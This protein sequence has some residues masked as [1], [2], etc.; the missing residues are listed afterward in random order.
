MLLRVGD[1]RVGHAERGGDGPLGRRGQGERA[2]APP[3]GPLAP[4]A[5]A[6]NPPPLSCSSGGWSSCRCQKRLLRSRWSPTCPTAAATTRSVSSLSFPPRPA[7]ASSRDCLSCQMNSSE[8]SESHNGGGGD[9]DSSESDADEPSL[10]QEPK[11]PRNPSTGGGSQPGSAVHRPRGRQLSVPLTHTSGW[12]RALTCA[13]SP[14]GPSARAGASWSMDSGSDDS[15]R[16]SD[17]LSIDE[18]DGFVFVNYSEGQSKPAHPSQGSVPQPLPPPAT[19]PRTYNQLRAGGWPRFRR[20][21]GFLRRR[22]VSVCS[23]ATGGSGSSSSGANSPCTR[24]S[25]ART[26]LTRLRSAPSP[27]P[28]KSPALNPTWSLALLESFFTGPVLLSGTTVRSW[29]ATDAAGSSAGPSA[30]SRAARPPTTG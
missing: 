21:L 22:S 10:S 20:S 1:E 11:A 27:S 29:W 17:T 6:S 24:R 4:R 18:K 14:E 16:W 26:T 3:A 9:D 13:A 25:I 15:H 23:Q 19:E 2:S 28:S 8:G 30:S 12:S 7:R 5:P